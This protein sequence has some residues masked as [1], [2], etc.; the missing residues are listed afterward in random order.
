MKE[1]GKAL[2]NLQRFQIIE[3]KLNPQT[4]N[5][6]PDHY[7]YAWYVELF[8]LYDEMSLHKDLEPYFTITRK[9]IE[10]IKKRADDEWLKERMHS[11]YDYE[12]YFGSRTDNKDG[13][14]RAVLIKVFRYMYLKKF[15]DEIFWKKLLEPAKFPAEAEIIHSKSRVLSLL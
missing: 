5:L 8:P 9:Q 4:H 1:I 7:A 13:I 3:T 10:K 14:T 15:W 11:F 2:Y 6:I 12:D